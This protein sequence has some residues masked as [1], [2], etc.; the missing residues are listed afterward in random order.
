MFDKIK[1]ALAACLSVICADFEAD[2]M[3]EVT[4]EQTKFIMG[5]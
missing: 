2:N 5:K 1:E 3:Y 4:A